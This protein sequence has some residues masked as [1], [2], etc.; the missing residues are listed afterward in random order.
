MIAVWCILSTRLLANPPT[1]I[2]TFNTEY[3]SPTSEQ[4]LWGGGGGG[5]GDCTLKS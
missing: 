4:G 1:M 5:G 3:E 2:I